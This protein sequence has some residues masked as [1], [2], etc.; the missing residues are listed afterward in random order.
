MGKRLVSYQAGKNPGGDDRYIEGGV[1]PARF[2]AEGVVVACLIGEAPGPRG[3]DRSH[4]PF[5]GDRSGKLVYEVLSR[6]NLAAIPEDAWSHWSGRKLA[7]RELVPTLAGVALTNAYPRCPTRDGSHFCAPSLRQLGEREN[8]D[9]LAGEL[10]EAEARCPVVL[11]L[12]ALGRHAA[13]VLGKLAPRGR[14]VE[15]PHP[16]ARGLARSGKVGERLAARQ[17]RWQRTLLAI[18]RRAQRANGMAVPIRG[19]HTRC[20]VSRAG[21]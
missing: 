18:L 2:P 3:A 4:I 12:V 11:Y 5:W 16:S 8:L 9:R 7:Q 10:A 20:N 19:R 13:W 15:L 17:A 21:W 6:A 1:V 14:V